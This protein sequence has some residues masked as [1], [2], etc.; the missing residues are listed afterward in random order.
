MVLQKNSRAYEGMVKYPGI[1]KMRGIVH[2]A[3]SLVDF[4][5]VL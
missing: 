3:T 1:Y 5:P 4:W 2:L